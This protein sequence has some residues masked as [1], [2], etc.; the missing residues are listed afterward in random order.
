MF[1]KGYNPPAL[2]LGSQE[3]KLSVAMLLPLRSIWPRAAIAT[4]NNASFLVDIVTERPS[5]RLVEGVPTAA[6]IIC[7]DAAAVYRKFQGTVATA[8]SV[9]PRRGPLLVT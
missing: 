6:N 5:V 1:P 8:L 9:G 4:A 7:G 2:K 3:S